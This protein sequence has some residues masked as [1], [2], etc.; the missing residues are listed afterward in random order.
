MLRSRKLW[1]V[2]LTFGAAAALAAPVR[3]A[4]IDKLTPA[5]AQAVIV[6]NVRQTI[7]SPLAKK[8]GIVDKMKDWI[9]A[10]PQAKGAIA[11]LGL[12]LTK[13]IESVTIAVNSFADLQTGKPEKMLVIV[14][15][16]FDPDRFEAFAKTSDTIKI[17]KEG[18][19]TVYENKDK[20][21]TSYA[22]LIGKNI[23]A[24]SPSKDYLLQ[25]VKNVGGGSKDLVKAGAKADGKNSMWMAVVVT[26]EMRK[27]MADN[28]QL[29]GFA[30]KLES[31]TSGVNVSDSIVLDLNVNTTDG[32]AA[33]A[34]ETQINAFLPFIRAT[35]E[36][37]EKNGALAKEIFSNLKIAAGP[38]GLNV[39][40]KVSE[41]TL[42]KIIKASGK[43]PK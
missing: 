7:D 37:D 1:L 26:D 14:R 25:S 27:A 11:A 24:V 20:G 34:I 36:A 12:D 3:A 41:D 9:S 15:G 39:N 4:E 43:F 13:D 32:D 18:N 28:P 16:N 42:D 5:D 33:K 10:N 8:K 29:K 22:T 17:T 31:I 21:E 23:M 38:T 30:N 35:A 19:L 2:A 6:F 40:L